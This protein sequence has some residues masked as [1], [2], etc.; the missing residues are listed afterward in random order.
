VA[1]QDLLDLLKRVD[2]LILNDS[3]A[4]ELAGTDNVIR[5]GRQLQQLGPKYV[6]VKKGEHGCVLFGPEGRLFAA[7]AF[8]LEEVNDPTGAGD[9]FAGGFVG[10]LAAANDTSFDT[11]KQA[12]ISGSTIAS[13]NVEEFSSRRLERLEP[14]EV[15]ARRAAFTELT[16][17]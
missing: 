15:Q 10:H 3:E 1:R 5:A 13:F 12:V 14:A 9:C 4:R 11:L 16:R 7:P 6:A 8:P 17:F 2:M